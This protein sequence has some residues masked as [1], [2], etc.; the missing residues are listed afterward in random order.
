MLEFSRRISPFRTTRIFLGVL[1]CVYA[2]YL[3]GFGNF[4]YTSALTPA[5][6]E[7]AENTPPDT[8]VAYWTVANMRSA[9]NADIVANNPNLAQPQ[10]VIQ[11]DKGKLQQGQ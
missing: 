2:G 8:A 5:I 9:I 10:Q 3:I 6:V 11:D 1:A 4:L 7:H